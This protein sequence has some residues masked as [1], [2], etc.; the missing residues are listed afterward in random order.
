MLKLLFICLTH[1]CYS[2]SPISD[3]FPWQTRN[4]RCKP[5]QIHLSQGCKPEQIHLSQGCKPEQIHLSQGYTPE[6][7]IVDWLD[8]QS[9]TEPTVTYSDSSSL[10]IFSQPAT[11]TIW[12]SEGNQTR[13]LYRSTLTGLWEGRHYHYQVGPA[14]SYC[15]TD[16]QG[17]WFEPIAHRSTSFH[18]LRLGIFGDYGVVND[19]SQTLLER[20]VLG[21]G[22]TPFS[23]PVILPTIYTIMMVTGGTILCD[24]F[25]PSPVGYHI[26]SHPA[27]TKNTRISAIIKCVSPC[28]V[29]FRVVKA[30]SIVASI[31]D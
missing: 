21:G 15:R 3:T 24:K 7:M 20:K 18:P 30:P 22:L 11:E 13:Y 28:P 23:T 25:P 16:E 1:V 27:T 14:R 19:Q 8:W 31:W 29:K 9:E 2:D 12:V 4:M 17:Q 10:E 5:E 26:W 6:S